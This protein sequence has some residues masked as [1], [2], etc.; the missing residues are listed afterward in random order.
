M[1]D[2]LTELFG[3]RSFRGTGAV[4]DYFPEAPDLSYLGRPTFVS[5]GSAYNPNLDPASMVQAGFSPRNVM[6]LQ[7]IRQD[8]HNQAEQERAMY[9]EGNALD[10]LSKIDPANR[11]FS[12]QLLDIFRKNPRAQQ[13][14]NVLGQVELLSKFAPKTPAWSV[15]DIEDPDVYDVAVKENWSKLS[16]T[17]A[18]RRANKIMNQRT[19]RG[20]LASLGLGPK[21]LDKDWTQEDYLREKGRLLR[22]AKSATVKPWTERLSDKEREAVRTE[23]QA[24]MMPD[25]FTTEFEGVKAQNPGITQEE[26]V[27][28]YKGVNSL[29]EYKTKR[30]L[31]SGT[32][33]KLMREYGLSGKEVA[34]LLGIS[35]PDGAAQQAP[36][37]PQWP[38]D[39]P[40]SFG[41]PQAAP[42]AAPVSTT[43][44]PA[45]PPA[46]SPQS[47]VPKTVPDALWKEY[48]DL[49]L[50][51]QAN[52]E[53]PQ[54]ELDTETIKMISEDSKKFNAKRKEI[55]DSLGLPQNN[56][57][58]EVFDAMVRA[59]DR[60]PQIR[61][62]GI[63]ATGKAWK[64]LPKTS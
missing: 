31:E 63:T 24:A 58:F 25:D 32:P 16:P 39:V 36:A 42:T 21:E 23:V 6:K 4:D 27:R 62:P 60:A 10:A 18:K 15:E 11:N 1:A 43:P 37:S 50:I 14:Q 49:D 2:P 19:M 28:K 5:R 8:L 3:R 64:I 51:R 20:E 29:D 55:M 34:S 22:E 12:T 33:Q 13:S 17:E 59:K 45:Q 7:G 41:Q 56:K 47:S 38:T 48:E 52:T 40:T 46:P 53:T 44:E 26:Y 54:N 57:G 61:K 9:D 35:L 30:A